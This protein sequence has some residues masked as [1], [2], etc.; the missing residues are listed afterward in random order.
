MLTLFV[1]CN[2][3]DDNQ[4]VVDYAG[5]ADYFINNKTTKDLVL[6]FKKTEEL[7]FWVSSLSNPLLTLSPVDNDDWTITSQELGDS[8]FGFTNYETILT[9]SIL[10]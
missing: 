10:D 3:N 5:S 8:G 9:D 6:I 4:I 1:S 7:G 2:D